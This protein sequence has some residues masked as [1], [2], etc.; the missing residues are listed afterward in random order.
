MELGWLF[1]KG[2]CCGRSA[3]SL[4]V[5]LLM[6]VLKGHT[7]SAPAAQQQQIILCKPVLRGQGG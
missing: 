7:G 3:L 5:K 4:E 6:P 2:L 1:L